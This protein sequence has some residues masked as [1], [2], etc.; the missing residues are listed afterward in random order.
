MSRIF[1]KGDKLIEE[2]ALGTWMNQRYPWVWCLLKAGKSF[3]TA[4]DYRTIHIRNVN[5]FVFGEL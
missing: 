2:I 4:S 3:L 5:V 1:G